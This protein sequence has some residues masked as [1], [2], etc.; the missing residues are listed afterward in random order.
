MNGH[1]HGVR[2]TVV[3]AIGDH[4]GAVSYGSRSHSRCHR[5]YLLCMRP[6][7]G[8][9]RYSR[10]PS[11]S[12]FG[13]T[14]PHWHLHSICAADIL[15][16]IGEGGGGERREQRCIFEKYVVISG[17][18]FR[19]HLGLGVGWVG[20]SIVHT[21]HINSL[22]VSVV[23]VLKYRSSAALVCE[24]TKFVCSLPPSLFFSPHTTTHRQTSI[25]LS[26]TTT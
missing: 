21:I 3:R 23:S 19:G 8:K 5:A 26:S 15:D 6:G 14:S 18:L 25:S 16:G 24:K 11:P 20:Y 10:R 1:G 12:L 7:G 22:G 9:K 13:V 2:I 17:L 4:R